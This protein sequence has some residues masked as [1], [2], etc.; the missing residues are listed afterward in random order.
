MYCFTILLIVDTSLIDYADL[1]VEIELAGAHTRGMT[2]C[3]LRPKPL[4]T[5]N[6]RPAPNARVAVDAKSRQLIDRV[7]DALLAYD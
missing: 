5:F 7:L 3:D 1:H 4:A 6:D 2:L